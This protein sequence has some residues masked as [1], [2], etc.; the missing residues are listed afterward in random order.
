METDNAPAGAGQEEG[1]FVESGKKVFVTAYSQLPAV[2]QTSKMTKNE[3]YLKLC[4]V[5]LIVALLLVIVGVLLLPTVFYV[6]R[7]AEVSILSNYGAEAT[8]LAMMC[9]I[10]IL[11]D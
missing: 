10:G 6:Q 4:E 11:S 3:K 2:K 7:V 1:V 5:L 9:L 8:T